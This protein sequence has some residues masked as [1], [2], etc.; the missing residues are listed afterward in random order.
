[1]RKITKLISVLVAAVLMLTMVSA[2]AS[3]STTYEV[4]D[5]AIYIASASVPEDATAYAL[6]K[7]SQFN[8]TVLTSLG[9]T[10]DEASDLKVS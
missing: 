10:E 2:S 8:V 1:M 7:F 3:S 6:D 9:F 5:D 4:M